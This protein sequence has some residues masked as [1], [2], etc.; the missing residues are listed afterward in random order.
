[1]KL[2]LLLFISSFLTAPVFAADDTPVPPE[3]QK[4]VESM[5]TAFKASDDAALKACWVTPEVAGKQKAAEATK[6][7]KDP[8]KEEEKEIKRQTRNL[9]ATASRAAQMRTVMSK[10]FGEIAQITLSRVELDVDEDAT[11]E[12]PRYSNV[13]IRLR[14]GDGTDLKVEIDDAVKINDVWKFQGRI[15]DEITIELPDED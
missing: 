14:T 12:K 3:V 11:P 8:A 6:E 10:H 13:K 15:D 5:L 1:M 2:A 9:E 4:L 7:G